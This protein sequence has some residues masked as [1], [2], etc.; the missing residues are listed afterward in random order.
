[1]T[2]QLCPPAKPQLESVAVRPA[3]QQFLSAAN[4]HNTQNN[5]TQLVTRCVGRRN[6][7]WPMNF[8]QSPASHWSL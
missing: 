8:C 1:M 5:I 4:G 7:A 3:P 2:L 6:P